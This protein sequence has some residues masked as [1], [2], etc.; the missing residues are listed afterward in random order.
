MNDTIELPLFEPPAL[1]VRQQGFI[2]HLRET[3]ALRLV[4]RSTCRK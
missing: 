4:T 2:G 1:S 3:I